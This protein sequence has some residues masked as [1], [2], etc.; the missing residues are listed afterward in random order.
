M[1]KRG[2][3]ALLKM[4]TLKEKIAG[5]LDGI[6]QT[7]AKVLRE[8]LNHAFDSLRRLGEGLTSNQEMYIKRVVFRKEDDV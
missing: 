6:E 7:R 8:R 4:L 2:T 5:T 1:S 3:R